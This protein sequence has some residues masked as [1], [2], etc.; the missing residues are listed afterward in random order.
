MTESTELIR[1]I[2]WTKLNCELNSQY[3]IHVWC[4]AISPCSLLL[5]VRMHVAP[6]DDIGNVAAVGSQAA[7]HLLGSHVFDG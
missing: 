7:H 4:R 2:E 3:Y 1:R 5:L 6:L